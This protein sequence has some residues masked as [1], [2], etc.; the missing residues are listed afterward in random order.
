MP[1]SPM[2]NYTTPSNGYQY[3]PPIQPQMP[4]QQ[5]QN[6]WQPTQNMPSNQPLTQNMVSPIQHRINGRTITNP[7][8]ISPNEVPM[9]MTMSLFPLQDNSVIIGKIWDS[10]GNLQTVRYVPEQPTQQNAQQDPFAALMQH[11]DARMDAIED[12]LNR[13]N[14]YHKP[15]AYRKNQN[16]NTTEQTGSD[17]ND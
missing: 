3:V 6:N 12:K 15:N 11:I 17:S 8:E 4:Y 9:D 10:N 5:F 1:V 16:G 14:K 2:N 7:N 13:R